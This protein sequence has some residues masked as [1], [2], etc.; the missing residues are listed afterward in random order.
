M[1]ILEKIQN[2]IPFEWFNYDYWPDSKAF[3]IVLNQC[4]EGISIQD[5]K[6]NIVKFIL[7]IINMYDIE[8][9]IIGQAKPEIP[10]GGMTMGVWGIE[11]EEFFFDAKD[12]LTNET[13]EY[14][15]LLSK[16]KI[17][18]DY[19][20]LCLC[21]NWEVLTNIILNCILSGS[22]P[23][24]PLIYDLSNERIIYF[25]HTLTIGI[26][27]IKKEDNLILAKLAEINQLTVSI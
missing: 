10:W 4:Y 23:F 5:K 11:A 25:H 14:L 13:E 6:N 18:F 20:G 27:F 21:N 16:S 19:D 7:S 9:F 17:N 1:F 15:N 3:R 24:S 12:N 8:D 22:A 26:Y 2:P